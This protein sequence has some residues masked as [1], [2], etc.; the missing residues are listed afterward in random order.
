MKDSSE[1]ILKVCLC[2][3]APL[4]ASPMDMSYFTKNKDICDDCF[5]TK[6]HESKK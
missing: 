1:I 5:V 2:C 6:N 3:D 4:P